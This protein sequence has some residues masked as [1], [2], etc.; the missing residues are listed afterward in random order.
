MKRKLLSIILSLLLFCSFFP[1]LDAHADVAP[2]QMPPGANLDPGAETTQVRMMAETV[3]LNIA[4]DPQDDNGAIA[5]TVATFTMRN[6]GSA[7]ESMQAR[8][9]LSFFDG[10]SDGSGNFPEI[11]QIAV[12]VDGKSVATKR[13]IEPAAPSSGGYTE[14]NDVPWAA[15]DVTFPPGRD[16]TIEVLYTTNGFGYYPYERFKYILET[17]AAWNDTIGSAD[18]I[19]RFPYTVS[20]QNIWLPDDTNGF[21]QTSPNATL[22]GNEA[23]WHFD[24]LEPTVDSN[25]ELTIVTPALW[26]QVLRETDTVTKN[27]ND[28]EAW[29]HLG[30]DYKEIAVMSKHGDP[31]PDADG[32]QMLR[33]SRQAYENCLA[34]LPNDPLWHFGY[35]DLLWSHYYFDIYMPHEPDTEGL[36]SV[37]LHELKTSLDLD[38]NNQRAKD[39]LTWISGSIPDAVSISDSGID[40]LALTATLTPQTPLLFVTETPTLAPTVE[41]ISSPTSVPTIPP[42]IP[43]SAATPTARPTGTPICGG[44]GLI[45]PLL[46]GVLWWKRKVV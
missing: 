30:K 1:S 25:I 41:V 6:L 23:R 31:R 38:P 3:I 37:I 45:L 15:F 35:A 19:A 10:E 36:L 9:P 2:P 40:Y 28:G 12:K 4:Q 16:V 21:S 26:Q 8:F 44:A 17:G 24:N 32:Q 11:Q 34:L 13:V 27:P 18:I 7:D 46:V 43:T 29:G 39:L 42:S 22:N 5:K 14:R 20:G 33:L